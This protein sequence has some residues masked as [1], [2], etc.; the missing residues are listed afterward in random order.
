[1]DYAAFELQVKTYIENMGNSG[2]FDLVRCNYNPID[3][4]SFAI[5]AVVWDGVADNAC[6][7]T[8]YRCFM[9]KLN[10]LRF[11]IIQ[12]SEWPAGV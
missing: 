2:P 10:V 12:K 5:I 4:K 1:M 8:V 3:G 7:K 9:N 11:V 6:T